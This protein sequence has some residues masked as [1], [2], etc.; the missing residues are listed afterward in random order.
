[1]KILKRFLPGEPA[2]V[3]PARDDSLDDITV[4]LA[5][6]EK[7]ATPEPDRSGFQ[8][9]EAVQMAAYSAIGTRK[10]QQDAVR[11]AVGERRSVAVLC[12]GMGG[13]SGGERASAL[14]AEGMLRALTGQD[15]ADIPRAMGR[16]AA[17]LNSQVREL[18]DDQ[19]R[20]IEAG[21][22]LTAVVVE[23]GRLFW[24]NIGD[25]RIYLYRAGGL[26]QLSEDHTLGRQLDRL[27]REGALSPAEARCHPGRA[28]L[29]N[30]VGMP[31]MS[32][33]GGN[34][35]GIPLQS[36]DIVVQCSDGLYRCLTEEEMAQVLGAVGEQDLQ[37]AAQALVQAAL[38]L[39]GPHDNTSVAL[40][41]VL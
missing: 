12:D 9:G 10:S 29:T 13:L 28:A 18:C 23:D 36:Q 32:E 35:R 6:P 7:A 2:A 30:Y 1:M 31:D 25:S 21:T 22:T 40:T 27:V 11:F 26:E 37:Q 38:C 16:A 41:C 24:C 39:P 8:A 14:A 33:I 20:K 5:V 4:T 15:A 34:R 19:D 3:G 17:R